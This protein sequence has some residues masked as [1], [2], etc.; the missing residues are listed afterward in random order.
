MIV[1]VITNKVD[2]KKYVGKTTQ[3]LRV[4]WNEHLAMARRRKNFSLYH[5]INQYGSESFTLEVLEVVTQLADLRAATIRWISTLKTTDP[6]CGYNVAAG[7]DRGLDPSVET[8]YRTGSAQRGR[9]RTQYQKD[10]VSRA[11]K[12]KPKPE[13]QRLKMAAHWDEERRDQQGSVA[14]RVNSVENLKRKD[15]TCPLCNSHFS[16]VARGVYGGHRKA[17]LKK[18]GS[19]HG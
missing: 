8:R 5:A 13:S 10:A 11:L 19:S 1:Y 14:R 15:Y 6:A 2:G 18:H 17:C 4:L 3:T 7:G 12:G 9:P 16:Q